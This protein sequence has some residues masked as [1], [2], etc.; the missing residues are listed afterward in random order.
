M[1]DILD[2]PSQLWLL[3]CILRDDGTID[4]Q[5]G[6][7]V[8]TNTFITDGRVSG[9]FDH[10]FDQAIRIPSAADCAGS[11]LCIVLSDTG[12]S[13]GNTFTTMARAL[14]PLTK[15]AEMLS[16]VSDDADRTS[17]EI[18]KVA[19]FAH[20]IGIQRMQDVKLAFE[21]KRARRGG[22][23]GQWRLMGVIVITPADNIEVFQEWMRTYEIKTLIHPSIVRNEK[24]I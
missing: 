24:S 8:F 12:Y 4:P 2:S 22:M 11:S 20:T 13:P 5:I 21:R 7:S 17:I 6:N 15:V 10:V 16:G 18:E 3:S 23:P 9:V 19:L 14:I 1:E